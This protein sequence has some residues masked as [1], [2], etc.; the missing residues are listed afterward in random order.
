MKTRLLIMLAFV[1]F[2]SFLL[3]V[4]AS[5]APMPE[6]SFR[7]SK[8]VLVGKILS[9]EIISEPKYSEGANVSGIALY[10]VKVE[11]TLKN[12]IDE[13]LTFS[14]D[15]N[16]I[17]VPG[18][19][20]REIDPIDVV[21]YPYEVNQ[22]VLL[23]IQI[24]SSDAVPDFDYVIRSDTSKVIGDSLCEEGK[25]FVKG[26][27]V[28]EES[29]PSCKSGPMPDGEGW[30]FIDCNWEQYADV[31]VDSCVRE[32]APANN[33]AWNS[34]DC[35]WEWSPLRNE[36]SSGPT[37]HLSEEK[38]S[39]KLTD[40]QICGSGNKLINGTCINP[41][42]EH[43]DAGLNQVLLFVSIGVILSVVSFIVWRKRK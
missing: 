22:R 29:L 28:I 36:N 5:P 10:T 1:L 40:E 8:Y 19:F 37:E 23:Y 25:K 34:Q 3:S 12:P 6:D 11:E 2:Q 32:T 15:T 16:I 38:P 41:N 14:N 4:Y 30:V 27:C 21:S 35:L 24:D 18:Y 13:N 43:F 42:V 31:P 33:Y 7:F 26:I 20:V 39:V 17:K 9:V